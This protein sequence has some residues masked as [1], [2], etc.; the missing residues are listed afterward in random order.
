M[1]TNPTAAFRLTLKFLAE[2]SDFFVQFLDD[3]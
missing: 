3:L 2:S 1:G